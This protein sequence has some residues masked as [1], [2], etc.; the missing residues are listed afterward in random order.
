MPAICVY[1]LSG[2]ATINQLKYVPSARPIAWF[3]ATIWLMIAYFII[4]NRIIKKANFA[5]INY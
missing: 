1:F 4:I 5:K 2:F 3:G